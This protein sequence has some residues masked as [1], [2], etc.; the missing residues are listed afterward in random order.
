M[1]CHGYGG[2]DGAARAEGAGIFEDRSDVGGP[3]RA[4]TA[5]F[6]KAKGTY[7]VTG[8]GANM[9]LAKDSFHFVWK[10]VSGDVTLAADIEFSG[11][12]VDPHRKACLLFRQSL[13]ADAVYADAALHGDGRP[14]SIS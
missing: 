13:D 2:G 1:L 11:K 10:K 14:R 8:G 6:D 12:G 5:V 4:G 9:W 3:A 7:T